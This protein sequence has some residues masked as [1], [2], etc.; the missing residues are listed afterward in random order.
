MPGGE[1]AR[2]AYFLYAPFGTCEEIGSK[3]PE[4]WKK[5][6]KNEKKPFYIIL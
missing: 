3:Q 1:I 4:K 6:E 5:L 2:Q